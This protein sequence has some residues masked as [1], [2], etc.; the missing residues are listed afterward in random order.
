[1]FRIIE[2]NTRGLADVDEFIALV[3]EPAAHLRDFFDQDLDI[4][5]ARAPGRL[6]VMGGI[7]D[8]SGSLVLPMPIAAATFAAVQKTANSSIKI[9]SLQLGSSEILEF[10]MDLRDLADSG[11]ID[12]YEQ[13]RKY[14]QIDKD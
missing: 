11:D 2:G 5:V 14:F 13:A 6:D 9:A 7:A 1:M 3:N 8:Y 4:F 10:E 12:H